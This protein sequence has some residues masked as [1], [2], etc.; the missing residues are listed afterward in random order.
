M[1]EMDC[2]AK[3]VNAK[4]LL[5]IFPECFILDV[6]KSPE[7][8]SWMLKSCFV[9][10]FFCLFVCFFSHLFLMFKNGA[11]RCKIK[12]VVTT[13]QTFSSLLSLQFHQQ[14]KWSWSLWDIGVVIWNFVKSMVSRLFLLNSL[15]LFSIH[16]I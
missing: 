16:Y 11:P 15:Y 6:W 4:K 12:C 14:K 5:A 3:R 2:L 13:H 7:M 1:A 10:L 9:F 8:R